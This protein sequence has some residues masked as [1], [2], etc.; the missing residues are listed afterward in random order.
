MSEANLW[1]AALQ[2]RTPKLA[3]LAEK[4]LLLI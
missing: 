1:S 4:E 3:L 2:R